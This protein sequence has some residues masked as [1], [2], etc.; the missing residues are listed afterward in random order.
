MMHITCSRWDCNCLVS[1]EKKVVYFVVVP[2]HN[3]EH[4]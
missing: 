3:I 1:S 4:E 2:D